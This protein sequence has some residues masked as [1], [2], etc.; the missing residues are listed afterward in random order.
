MDISDSKSDSKTF[1]FSSISAFL[2]QTLIA[3]LFLRIR[4]TQEFLWSGDTSP[5]ISRSYAIQYLRSV[6]TPYK[7][8]GQPLMGGDISLDQGSWF[9]LVLRSLPVSIGVDPFWAQRLEFYLVFIVA[10]LS[11]YLLVRWLNIQPWIAIHVGLLFAYGPTLFNFVTQ[12]WIYLAWAYALL[13]AIMLLTTRALR[14]AGFLVLW[15]CGAIAGLIAGSTTLAP[16]YLLMLSLSTLDYLVRRHESISFTRRLIRTSWF[17]SA[18]PFLHLFWFIPRMIHQRPPTLQELSRSGVSLGAVS[19]LNWLSPISM[20]GTSFNASFWRFGYYMLP[21]VYVAIAA[22]ALLILLVNLTR[23]HR[24]SIWIFGA[25]WVVI[26]VVSYIDQRAVIQILD[27]LGLGRDSARVVATASFPVVILFGYLM[28]TIADMTKNRF[29]FV[30]LI[31]AIGILIAASFPYLRPGISN[32]L[33]DREPG[34][35]LRSRE[36]N[37]HAITTVGQ[38]VSKSDR[39]WGVLQIPDFPFVFS[40]TDFRF[41]GTYQSTTNPWYTLATPV[42]FHRSDKSNTEYGAEWTDGSIARLPRDLVYT[43]STPS[44]HRIGPESTEYRSLRRPTQELAEKLRKFGIRF[45]IVDQSYLANSQSKVNLLSSS[46]DSDGQKLFKLI[47]QYEN[48]TKSGANSLGDVYLFEVVQSVGAVKAFISG[49]SAPVKDDDIVVLRSRSGLPSEIAIRK[50]MTNQ[51]SAVVNFSFPDNA[52][53]TLSVSFYEHGPCCWAAHQHKAD[54]SITQYVE[55]HRNSPETKLQWSKTLFTNDRIPRHSYSITIED[56][57]QR[58]G[59]IQIRVTSP[60]NELQMYLLSLTLIVLVLLVIVAVTISAIN[61]RS[62]LT[63]RLR[64]PGRSRLLELLK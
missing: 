11:M 25:Y 35:A 7:I 9:L 20:A 13:P 22:G 26:F 17:W 48:Q 5:I 15:I 21:G 38:I 55:A 61:R 41:D 28:Q 33:D 57:P 63:N 10:S 50:Q 36:V 43:I 42:S 6:I 44:L 54:A 30:M 24:L 64:D 60:I 47:G 29:K 2:T 14:E 40:D 53:V 39:N 31:A 1:K 58:E 12:G 49:Q 52:L 16:A 23:R 8:F 4:F 37:L 45:L 59:V 34:I 18:V 46:T 51:S 32:S 3:A 56:L 19:G 27:M 62:K